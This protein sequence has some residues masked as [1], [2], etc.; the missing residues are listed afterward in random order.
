MLPFIALTAFA[1]LVIALFIYVRRREPALG[2]IDSLPMTP[3]QKRAWWSLGIGVVLTVAIIVIFSI[4]GF[5]AYD[6][7]P[8]MRLLVLALFLGALLT[9]L[10][11]D[12]LGRGKGLASMD[13]RDQ[14]V[15][16]RAPRVQSV[17][18]IITLAIWTAAL[19]KVYHGEGVVPMIFL[20][21]IFFSALIVNALAFSAGILLGYRRMAR[22]GE[23]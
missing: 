21:M 19:T 14:I 10:F 6:E 13:E 20:Y 17:A 5:A 15:L 2:A 18:M 7:D 9:S 16:Q 11:L 12:S 4:R 3:L 23:G 1:L 8:S 22:Y